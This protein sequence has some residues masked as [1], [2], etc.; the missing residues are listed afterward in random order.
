MVEIGM[1]PED[2]VQT[3]SKV[4]AALLDNETDYDHLKPLLD[5]WVRLHEDY[6][7]V[8]FYTDEPSEDEVL[9]A[10]ETIKNLQV[11]YDE[12]QSVNEFILNE[13]NPAIPED[14]LSLPS[15]KTLH[16]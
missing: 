1:L 8:Y 13:T 16:D 2:E 5:A 14:S 11:D 10:I 4:L 6:G 7:R 3:V 15:V 9:S 12:F